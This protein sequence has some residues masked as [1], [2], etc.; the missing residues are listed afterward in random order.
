MI[1]FLLLVLIVATCMLAI[2]FHIKKLTWRID[3]L[4]AQLQML[5]KSLEEKNVN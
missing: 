1:I 5:H 2:Y 3:K 4:E